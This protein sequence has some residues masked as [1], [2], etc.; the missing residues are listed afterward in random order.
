MIEIRY[1]VVNKW[2]REIRD[3]DVQE[4][5]VKGS[6]GSF[7]VT[8]PLHCKAGEYLETNQTFLQNSFQVSLNSGLLNTYLRNGDIVQ[9]WYDTELKKEVDSPYGTPRPT[10]QE[11][12]ND[13]VTAMAKMFSD[14]GIT[15]DDLKDLISAVKEKKAGKGKTKTKKQKET[16]SQATYEQ[17]VN[18]STMPVDKSVDNFSNKDVKSIE[19]STINEE[20][21]P[22]V[23]NSNQV[24]NN[25]KK[26]QFKS[27]SYQNR[28]KYIKECNNVAFLQW[29]QTSFTQVAIFNAV[30]KRIAEIQEGNTPKTENK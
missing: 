2:L 22:L 11:N 20:D 12:P 13:Q 25:L 8:T 9:V 17:P 19:N 30:N 21:K 6:S 26:E 23:E 16:K 10:Q 28:L 7:G 29:I 27:M 18:N 24:V 3:I 4:S 1:R 15:T 5:S 14:A